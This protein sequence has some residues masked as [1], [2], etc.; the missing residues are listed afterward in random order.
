MRIV[1]EYGSTKY[2]INKYKNYRLLTI[3]QAENINEA[4]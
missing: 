2:L 4:V 3:K 1:M